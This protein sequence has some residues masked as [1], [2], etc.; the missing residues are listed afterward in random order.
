M[1]KWQEKERKRKEADKREIKSDL[2][3]E[4]FSTKYFNDIKRKEE[5]ELE[6]DLNS[7]DKMRNYFLKWIKESVFAA[8]VAPTSS[9]QGDKKHG[10]LMIT[11]TPSANKPEFVKETDSIFVQAMDFISKIT[12]DLFTDDAQDLEVYSLLDDFL[13]FSEHIDESNFNNRISASHKVALRRYYRNH[14]QTILARQKKRKRTIKGI[15]DDIKRKKMEKYGAT[16]TGKTIKKNTVQ[17]GGDHRR[18]L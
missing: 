14:K 13:H 17:T 16:K 11:R 15:I 10:G 18:A 5:K 12:P 1:H 4:Y 3:R 7:Y 8:A 9:R 6:P 2:V